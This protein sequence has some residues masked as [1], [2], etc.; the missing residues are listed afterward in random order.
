MYYKKTGLFY[1]TEGQKVQPAVGVL[2]VGT[3]KQAGTQAASLPFPL[4][5]FIIPSPC[6]AAAFP[7]LLQRL[8]SS[9]S[10][11]RNPK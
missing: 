1:K 7:L 2:K 10:F 3:G 9:V 8:F 4:F 6:L 5:T 11:E